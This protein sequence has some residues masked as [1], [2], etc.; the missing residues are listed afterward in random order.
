MKVNLLNEWTCSKIIR[1]SPRA[2]SA[3]LALLRQGSILLLWLACVGIIDQIVGLSP[4]WQWKSRVS[5][6]LS[7]FRNWKHMLI[8][9]I[10]IMNTKG[11]IFT[12]F[13]KKK[14]KGKSERDRNLRG[15][16]KNWNLSWGSKLQKLKDRSGNSYY[17]VN[18]VSISFEN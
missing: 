16:Y 5:S 15:C 1:V 17:S 18:M 8:I 2:V 4:P 6:F 14:E 12:S 13:L 10:Q 11:K 3:P 7:F 9:Q